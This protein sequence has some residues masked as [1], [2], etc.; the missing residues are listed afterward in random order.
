MQQAANAGKSA[1][2]SPSTVPT[3]T[4]SLALQRSALCRWLKVII[5]FQS[6]HVLLQA[7][8]GWECWESLQPCRC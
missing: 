1:H 5:H 4:L 7:G 3:G 2:R 8:G 6:T